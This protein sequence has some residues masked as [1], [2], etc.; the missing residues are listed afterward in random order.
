MNLKSI[1]LTSCLACGATYI[2]TSFVVG[3]K[4]E[5]AYDAYIKQFSEQTKLSFE[6]ETYTSGILSSDATTDIQIEALLP[7]SELRDALPKTITL[8]HHISHG[9]I[10]VPSFAP[11]FAVALITTTIEIPA[12]FKKNAKE[13]FGKNPP[14]KFLT[15]IAFNGAVHIE[16]IY[17]EGKYINEIVNSRWSKTRIIADIDSDYQNVDYSFSAPG[18]LA[19]A[20]GALGAFKVSFEAMKVSGH[21]VKDSSGLWLGESTTGLK[22]LDFE[23]KNPGGT[24]RVNAKRAVVTTSDERKDGSL[25][26][27]H[28]F[29]LE[30]LNLSG[31]NIGQIEYEVQVRNLDIAALAELQNIY[32]G[33][34][35]SAPVAESELIGRLQSSLLGVLPKLLARSPV[36]EVKR[37]SFRTTDGES[38]FKG[39][40]MYNGEPPVDIS[41]LGIEEVMSRT[42]MEADLNVPIRFVQRAVT[43]LLS[44]RKMSEG[45]RQSKAKRVAAAEAV[46]VIKAIRNGEYVVTEDNRFKSSLRFIDGKFT[47]NGNPLDSSV[48]GFT[49]QPADIEYANYQNGVVAGGDGRV[50]NH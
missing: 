39:S 44:Q 50:S 5:A 15:T 46:D 31:E 1:A 20:N 2:A 36:I 37:L 4:S 43:A 33:F 24:T 17:A 13:I 41:D 21:A 35:W 47:A 27:S 30:N 8:K 26:S 7:N 49:Q 6:N 9:P 14:L 28:T 32:S 11:T 48:V 25:D 12:E 10:V 38:S 18:F 40:V 42:R 29:K 34:G 45:V 23:M 16:A 22:N 19:L 3:N